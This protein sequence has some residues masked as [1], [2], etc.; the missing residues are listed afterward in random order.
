MHT[1][2]TESITRGHI[3]VLNISLIFEVNMGVK[4]NSI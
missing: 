1:L 3:N 4:M 2:R